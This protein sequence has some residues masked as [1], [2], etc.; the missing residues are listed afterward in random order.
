M[1]NNEKSQKKFTSLKIN[2]KFLNFEGTKETEKIHGKFIHKNDRV[3]VV[4][5][6]KQIWVPVSIAIFVLYWLM[7]HGIEEVQFEQVLE[8]IKVVYT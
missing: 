1:K 7:N 5:I 4:E 2:T 8:L 6:I 3:N